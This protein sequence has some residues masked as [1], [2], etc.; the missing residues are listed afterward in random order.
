MEFVK[1]DVEP[2]IESQSNLRCANDYVI[3]DGPYQ[4]TTK[5]CNSNKHWALDLYEDE[6]QLRMYFYSNKENQ[7]N[8]FKA[9][10]YAS[11]E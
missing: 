7:F 5:I 8:G 3:V 1:F 9:V 11:G 2:N 10:F 6:N 4:D